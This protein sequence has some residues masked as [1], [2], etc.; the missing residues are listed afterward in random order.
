MS[1]HPSFLFK[2]PNK[3]PKTC[4]FYPENVIP[5]TRCLNWVNWKG[6]RSSV[7]APSSSLEMASKSS[8][9][10]ST[11]D[12]LFREPDNFTVREIHYHLP[13]WDV[14][15]QGH[16]KRDD[17]LS[18]L[19]I[20]VDVCDIFL[21]F[22]GDIQGTYYDWAFPPNVKF[23]NNKS[24]AGFEDFITD[25]ILECLANGSLSIWGKVGLI[26]PSHLVMT[27]S[28]EPTKPSLCHDECFLNL[29][30]RDIPLTCNLPHY[31]ALNHFQSTMD[32]K[33][34]YNHVK[35]SP[36]SR[37]YFSLEWCRWYFMSARN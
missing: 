1:A 26:S 18:Y 27:L 12:L 22:K 32:D 10:A 23:S 33:S 7:A 8:V 17:I 30:I 36:N 35:S 31:V 11:H 13:R 5:R 4:H 37:T 6:E 3:C 9:Q 21:P 15:L 16:N 24:C 2:S 25:T 19:K 28:V 34:G 29:W 14:I 20:G